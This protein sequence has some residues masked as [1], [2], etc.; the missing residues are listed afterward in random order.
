MIRP[1]S[2]ETVSLHKIEC[3]VGVGIVFMFRLSIHH[4]QQ[5]PVADI[6]FGNVIEIDTGSIA[7]IADIERKLLFWILYAISQR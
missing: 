6:A 2:V 1:L 4:L 3:S 5:Q 7:Q